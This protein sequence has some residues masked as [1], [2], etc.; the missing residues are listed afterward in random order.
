MDNMKSVI[1]VFLVGFVTIGLL[2]HLFFNSYFSHETLVN[3]KPLIVTTT[4]MIADMV[5]QLVGEG[6]EVIAL[7]GPGVD[8]HMYRARAGDIDRLNSASLIIYNGIHLEGKMADLFFNMRSFKKVVSLEELIDQK[9]LLR[10]DG[11]DLYDPHI[12]HDVFLWACLVNP[13]AIVLKEIT[14]DDTIQERAI[15]YE[16]Q[17]ID[18]HESIIKDFEHLLPEKKILVTAHDAFRYF[19]KRYGV[20]VCGLQGVSTNAQA[21][22]FDVQKLARFICEKKIKTIFVESC[23]S[24]SGIKLLQES[25]I[26]AGWNV[27]IGPELYADALGDKGYGADTYITMIQSNVQNLLNAFN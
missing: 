2:L 10:V 22:L 7:M 19:G 12:W 20:A 5:M 11:T 4:G 13:L 6:A 16:K 25:V 9:S 21:G 15:L 17:L 8:P 24:D 3:K 23:V 14:G 18:L 1:K 27:A 26:A